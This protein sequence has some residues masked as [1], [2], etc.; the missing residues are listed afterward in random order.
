MCVA[1][2]LAVFLK[3]ALWITHEA[4][5]AHVVLVSS[6]PKAVLAVTNGLIYLPLIGASNNIIVIYII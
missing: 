5:L 4:H 2:T 6:D 1:E 3:W